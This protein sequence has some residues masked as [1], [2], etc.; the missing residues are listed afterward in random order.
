M[1]IP[2]GALIEIIEKHTDPNDPA[3][4]LPN[5]IRING[6]PVLAPAEDPVIVHEMDVKNRD[7]IKV[8]L[9]LYARRV[10]MGAER[11]NGES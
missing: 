7:A 2:E 3:I 11:E 9:T 6:T 8:T 4:I 1:A 10:T 5:E